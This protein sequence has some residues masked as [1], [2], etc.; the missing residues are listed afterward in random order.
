MAVPLPEGTER[1]PL[2]LLAPVDCATPPVTPPLIA[3]TGHV[4]VVPTGTPVGVTVK[5]VPVVIDSD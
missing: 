2:M 5:V 3:G 4:Y 1:V